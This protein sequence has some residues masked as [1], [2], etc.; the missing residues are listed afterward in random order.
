MT[1]HRSGSSP[2][3]GTPSLEILT[4]HVGPM[5]P[6]DPWCPVVH[7]TLESTGVGAGRTVLVTVVKSLF[8][9]PLVGPNNQKVWWYDESPKGRTHTPTHALPIPWVCGPH[10]SSVT[11]AVVISTSDPDPVL[12][13]LV[14]RPTHVSGRG[15]SLGT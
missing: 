12:S 9:G 7:T 6:W 1:V 11:P 8:L 13:T 15:P 14:P 5:I 3:P 4:C 2:D 10:A